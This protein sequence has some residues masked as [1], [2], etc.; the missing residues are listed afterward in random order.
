MRRVTALR[1]CG[2]WILLA[3][4]GLGWFVLLRPIALGGDVAYVVIR[5]D[6]M[7]PTFA[8][9]DLVL[10]RAEA[11]V[12]V[13]DIVAFRVPRGEVGA[14]ML[15]IHRVIG[16]EGDRLIL[17]GDNNP[18]VDPWTPAPGD[19]VGRPWLHVPAI[20]HMLALLH[21]PTILAA[22]A[23]SVVVTGALFAPAPAACP[24]RPARR[25]VAILGS[26]RRPV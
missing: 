13:G 3:L 21:D 4:V 26:A 19:V 1:R 22:L 23:A 7:E 24:R 6:S 9:G 20:G 25:Q 11:N 18:H 17:Q 8:T 2:W 16:T 14:G 12:A 5:G 15:V 10:T